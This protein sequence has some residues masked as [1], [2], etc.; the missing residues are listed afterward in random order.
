MESIQLDVSPVTDA[1]IMPL[2]NEE[3]AGVMVSIGGVRVAAKLPSGHRDTISTTVTS[4]KHLVGMIAANY[5]GGF[6]SNG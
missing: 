3:F 6:I 1:E 4:V 5:L 2:V